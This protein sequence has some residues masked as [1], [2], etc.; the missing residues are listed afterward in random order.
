MALPKKRTSA[1]RTKRRFAQYAFNQKRKLQKVADRLSHMDCPVIFD[2]KE[3]PKTPKKEVKEAPKA[4]MEKVENIEVK[5]DKKEAGTDKDGK[6]FSNLFDKKNNNSGKN[7]DFEQ[8]SS[9]K[10]FRRKSM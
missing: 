1:S 8:G 2:A 10:M 9:K 6:W 4:E 5:E 7:K 3:A